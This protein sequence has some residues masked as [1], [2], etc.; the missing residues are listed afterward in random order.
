MKKVVFFFF[1]PV[2]QLIPPKQGIESTSPLWQTVKG[3]I[4]GAEQSFHA[5]SFGPQNG[6][7]LQRSKE[8]AN[9]KAPQRAWSYHHKNKVI[10]ESR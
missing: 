3:Q 6:Q 5:L 8:P 9:P 4:D 2:V 10:S 1:H 7:S